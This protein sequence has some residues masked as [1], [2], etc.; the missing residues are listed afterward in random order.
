MASGALGFVFDI[1]QSIKSYNDA[2][3][4]VFEEIS[5]ALAQMRIYESME[6]VDTALLRQI[7][8]VLISVVRLSAHVVKYR[9]G[10]RKE[11]VLQKLKSGIFKDDSG[12]TDEMTVFKRVLQQQRDVESTVTLAN[13]VETRQEIQGLDKKLYTIQQG[14][15]P[16][17]NNTDRLESLTRIKDTLELPPSLLVQLG[18][19]HTSTWTRIPNGCHEG[20]GSWI[21]THE[22]YTQWTDRKERNPRSQVLFITGPPA[23][24]KSSACALIARELEDQQDRRYVAYHSFPKTQESKKQGSENKKSQDGDGKQAGRPLHLALKSIAYQIARVDMIVRNQLNK[25]CQDHS[26]FRSVMDLTILWEKLKIGAKESNAMYYLVFDGLDNLS[27][28]DAEA[29]VDWSE[30]KNARLAGNI[31]V[32]ASGRQGMFDTS[33]SG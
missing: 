21:R 14:L 6:K 30:S 8:L 4:L 25:A 18:D 28:S 7:H 5:S 26:A 13:V 3:N 29:L 22:A 20:T 17:I 15:Q 33:H 23:S 32:L 2:V 24:G 19:T 12:L 11:R 16:I 31:R 10:D 9:Q 1:P 27:S